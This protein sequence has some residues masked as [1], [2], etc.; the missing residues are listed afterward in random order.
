VQS[1]VDGVF[2]VDAAGLITFVNP[3][4]VAMLGR[5]SADLLGSRESLI[6]ADLAE[7]HDSAVGVQESDVLRALASGT[8]VSSA[9]ARFTRGDG[10]V[11]PVELAVGPIRE[12]EVITGAVVVF[13]DVSGRV[14]VEK[15]KNEFV[16][17]VSHELRTPLTSIRG[18]LGLLAGGLGGDLS[19]K[20]A[21]MVSIALESSERL[22]RLIADMLD[23]E[24]MESGSLTMAFAPCGIQSLVNSALNEVDA[25]ARQYGVRISAQNSDGIVNV[26]ADR[27]VQTLTNVLGNSIKF[28]P[29]GDVVTVSIAQRGPMVE[30]AVADH[31]RGIPADRVQRIFERFEQVDSS[32]SRE[33]GGTG[34]GL[35]ISRDIV[36]L[37]GGSIWA[38][39]VLGEGSTFRFTL[40]GTVMPPVKVEAARGEYPATLNG[41]AR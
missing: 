2:G 4:A 11:F 16:S 30:F 3:R 38:E 15:M 41:V 37:H 13:R 21:R 27:I 24:R 17:V 26:D 12:G 8:A 25:M 34:L 9:R 23:I 7:S 29:R 10:S 1:V 18:S 33:R 36:E 5:P 39:S 31:G 32:D 20:G 6:F 19:P 14:A 40:P 35:S 22:S 28:S